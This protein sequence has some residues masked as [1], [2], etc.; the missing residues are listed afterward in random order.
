VHVF[1]GV[2][3]H[4]W[5]YVC[6]AHYV[7]VHLVEEKALGVSRVWQLIWCVYKIR[8]KVEVRIY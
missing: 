3:C 6:D 8:T 2:V 1:H 7:Y 5:P 4:V